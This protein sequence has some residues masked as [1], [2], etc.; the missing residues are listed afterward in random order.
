MAAIRFTKDLL[1]SL[2]PGLKVYERYD[3]QTKNLQIRVRPNGRKVFSFKYARGKRVEI[4][5]YPTVT[6]KL[7][8]EEC[9][10]ILTRLSKEED[11]RPKWR[12]PSAP[13]PKKGKTIREL[14]ELYE[15]HYETLKVAQG[16]SAA[17]L[18]SL[19]SVLLEIGDENAATLDVRKWRDGLLKANPKKV[20]VQIGKQ[21]KYRTIRVTGNSIKTANRKLAALRDLFRWAVDEGYLNHNQAAE[22]KLLK[23]GHVQTKPVRALDKAQEKK[24]RTALENRTDFLKPLWLVGVNTGLRR[25]ELLRLEWSDIRDDQLYVHKSKTGKSRRIPLNKE[26]QRAL[27]E[28]KHGNLSDLIFPIGDFKRTWT[29][30][31]R[32]IDLPLTW[33]EC[34]RHTFATRL[35]SN[36]VAPHIVQRLLGHTTTRMQ[37]VYGHLLPDDAVDAV[38]KVAI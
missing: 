6:L 12:R 38:E 35:L 8:R 2:Q 14:F 33:N 16:F 13:R 24:L 30:I 27:R 34:T 3:T 29:S 28:W 32:E 4:G 37:E 7:A 21:R 19:R 15:P 25:A 23:E 26:A 11:P 9:G 5:D 1:D 18:M 20:P 22:L 10:R 17:G 36:G 31:R